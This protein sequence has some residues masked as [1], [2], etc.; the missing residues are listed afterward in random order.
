MDEHT[1]PPFFFE[2]FHRSLPRHGPGDEAST[3]KA[4]QLL[5]LLGDDAAPAPRAPSGT[6][7]SVL[8]VGCGTGAQTMV[9][10]KHLDARIV[11]LDFHQNFLDELTLRAGAEGLSA[12]IEARL[13]SMRDLPTWSERFDVVWAEGSFFIMGFAEALRACYQVLKPGGLLA[14]SELTWL[15]DDAPDE[16]RDFFALEYPAMADV[17]TNLGSVRAAGFELVGHF[18]LPDEAWLTP[19]YEPLGRRVAE[20]RQRYADDPDKAEFL[21]MVQMEI[22]VFRR[23]SRYYGYVFYLMKQ[24]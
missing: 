5:G 24:G 13:G 23:Y 14:C 3:V 22:D 12:K 17:A 2:I 15:R 9:L 11:A 16:C 4:L 10:A 19:F 21:D 20:L 18:T 8:D 7:L 1:L 6:P